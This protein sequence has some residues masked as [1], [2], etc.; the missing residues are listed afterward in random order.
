MILCT[1]YKNCE[2]RFIVINDTLF[3]V[4]ENGTD[5]S[6]FPELVVYLTG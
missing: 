6:A 4:K 3:F 5:V 1:P 2:K